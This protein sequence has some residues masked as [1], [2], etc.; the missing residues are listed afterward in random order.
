LAHYNL[1]NDQI[2]AAWDRV[3]MV[4]N[5]VEKGLIQTID[6]D[7]WKKNSIGRVRYENNYIAKIQEMAKKCHQ[8]DY[9]ANES[10]KKKIEY[11]KEMSSSATEIMMKNVEKIAELRV[12]MVDAKAMIFDSSEY[13]LMAEQ[14]EK[15]EKITNDINKNHPGLKDIPEE[16]T[17]ALR[18]AYIQLAENTDKYIALKSLVPSTTRGEKRLDFA[19]GL[20]N[21]ANDTLEDLGFN[22]YKEKMD[23]EIEVEKEDD[24][25]L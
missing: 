5:A 24:M 23:E 25:A 11:A 22:T 14:F 1:S 9:Y 20:R 13:K 17:N 2:E 18:D 4:K 7:Y 10:E 3:Q 12:K 19:K 15:I 16:K 6:K 8:E 21:I